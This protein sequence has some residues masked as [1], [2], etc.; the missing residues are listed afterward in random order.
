MARRLFR[1]RG[2]LCRELFNEGNSE[3][4][5]AAFAGKRSRVEAGRLANPRYDFGVR[6]RHQAFARGSPGQRAL[7]ARHGGEQL[8]VGE[9][10]GAGLVR[11]KKLEAQ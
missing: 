6:R 11:E 2:H 7:E 3:G 5:A 9:E 8:L 1:D 10:S 4:A